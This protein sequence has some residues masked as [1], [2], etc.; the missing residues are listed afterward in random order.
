M[1]K[2][3]VMFNPE[4]TVEQISAHSS[5]YTGMAYRNG[6][7]LWECDLDKYPTDLTV[8]IYP[9]NYAGPPKTHWT[10]RR[11]L[12]PATELARLIYG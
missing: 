6:Q 3:L 4:L 5:S 8:N 9:L 7:R 2:T 10:L 1:A 12:I 11:Y